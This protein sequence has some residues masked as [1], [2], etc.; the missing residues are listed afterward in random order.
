MKRPPVTGGFFFAIRE[1]AP[2]MELGILIVATGKPV[3]SLRQYPPVSS[4]SMP[5]RSRLQMLIALTHRDYVV[6]FAGAGLG[7]GWLFVQYLFQIALFYLIFGVVLGGGVDDSLGLESRRMTGPGFLNYLL[8]AMTL[9][10]PLSEMILR[11][12][13]ILSENRA[14]IRR[15]PGAMEAMSYIPL[16]QAFLHFTILAIPAYLVAAF[17]EPKGLGPLFPLSYITGLAFLLICFPLCLYLQRVSVLLKDLSPILRLALQILFWS[18][19]M[20]YLIQDAEV[21]QIMSWNPLFCMVDIQRYL[22]YAM[23]LQQVSAMPGLLLLVPI[24]LIAGFL[25][26]IRLKEVCADFL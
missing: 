5:F 12:G 4:C 25:S 17:S 13:A 7:I 6:Q 2:T 3:D 1:S 20:V 14:L 9:W 8:G 23:P 21:L 16:A 19:P 24:S 11:S 18:T 15:T 26:R 22:S 10:L